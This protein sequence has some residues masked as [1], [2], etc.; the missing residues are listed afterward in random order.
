[1]V[2]LIIILSVAAVILILLF[3]PVA[4]SVSFSNG[5]FSAKIKIAGIKVCELKDEEKKE[6]KSGDNA[7][8]RD[9]A[10][11]KAEKNELKEIFVHLKKRYG[12]AGAVR[13]IFGFAGQVLKKIKKRLKHFF[14]KKVCVNIVIAGD[15]AAQTAV[16]YGA[17]CGSVYPVLAFL[18]STALISL[19]KINIS[20]DFYSGNSDFSF[21]LDAGARVIFLIMTLF[22]IFSEY[23]KFKMRNEL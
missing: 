7:G 18:E 16:E 11:K 17:V 13:E 1:M 8:N 2:P 9:A 19:K 3:L 5:D 23:N 14:I 10:G 21:S 6:D 4:L 12:F 15:D 22:D 20:S